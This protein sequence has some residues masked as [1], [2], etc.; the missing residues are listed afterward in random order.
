MKASKLVFAVLATLMTSNVAFAATSGTVLLQGTVAAATDISV[1]ENTANN[2]SLNIVG[3]ESNKNVATATETSNN[4]AGYKVKISSATAGE[5]RN[6]SDVTKKTTYKIAYDGAT[7][8]SP[9]VAGVVVKNVT[10]LSGL[11]SATSN[12][13]VDVTAYSTAPAGLYS[14]TL[15]I[16]IE[17]N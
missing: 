11:T 5:L 14:D 2:T 10:S 16:A 6:T 12:V 9:T 15:T 13:N 3:G 1:V 4:L 17:A 8:V 7:A